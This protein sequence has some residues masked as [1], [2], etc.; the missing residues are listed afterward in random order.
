MEAATNDSSLK[1]FFI[2]PFKAATWQLPHL[3]NGGTYHRVTLPPLQRG[4]VWRP[5]QI[6][7]LWDSLIRGFPIGFFLLAPYGQHDPNQGS[8]EGRYAAKYN[9][10]DFSHKDGEQCYHLLDGQQ[11]WNAITLGFV[12]VWEPNSVVPADLDALWVDLDEH[13]GIT[14]G[15]EFIFRVVTR[16]H[17]WGYQLN[18]P[19][20]RL[21]AQHRR[22]ALEAYET[23]YSSPFAQILSGFKDC[24]RVSV[25]E[26]VRHDRDPDYSQ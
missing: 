3:A 7:M 15:R 13:E 14:D 26:E 19:S 8:R 20:Q 4:E 18:D 11:R 6:E 10:A 9:E 2:S 17:P 24:G 12:N 25:A 5:R 22:E 1:P 16:S 21:S 23:A